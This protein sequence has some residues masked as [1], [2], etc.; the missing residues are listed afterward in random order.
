[1]ISKNGALFSENIYY[2]KK[3]DNSTGLFN[4]NIS[5]TTFSYPVGEI[6]HYPG[7]RMHNI[8][9]WWGYKQLN[10][11]Y[12]Y[13]N[14][15]RMTS[16]VEGSSANSFSEQLSY[17]KHGNI[18]SLT[19]K[20]ILENAWASDG[21]TPQ[22]RMGIID[23]LTF[24]PYQGNQILNVSDA[25]VEDQLF[26]GSQDFK[27]N[28]DGNNDYAYDANGNMVRDL[29][30]N[31]STIRYNFL[32]LPDTVQM[33]NG[34]YTAYN[35]DATGGIIRIQHRTCTGSNVSIPLGGTVVTNP[36][37]Y[38]LT[39][40]ANTEFYDNFV[41]ESERVRRFFID[42]G[43]VMNMAQPTTPTATPDFQYHFYLK[44]HLGNIRVVF[45]K[46]KGTGNPD[47][48][49]VVDQVNNYYPFG[50]EFGESAQ[51]QTSKTYQNHL[52][53]GK[54]FDNKFQ[55]NT[56]N[57]GARELNVDI[58]IWRT[59]D[60]LAEK[61]PGVSPYVY[62]L[63]NPINSIDPDGREAIALGVLVVKGL[64][65]AGIDIS[66]QMTANRTLFNQSFGQAFRNIDWTSAGGSFVAGA[67]GIPGVTTISKTAKVATIAT[68]V[69][70]DAAVDVSI[71]EGN[72]NI[73]NGEKSLRT[74]SIDA[75]GSLIGGKSS[76][77]IVKGAKNSISND[78]RSGTF[79]TLNNAEK[80]TLRQTKSV[81]NSQGF[82]AGTKTVVGLGTEI[83]KQRAKSIVGSGKPSSTTAPLMQNYTQPSDNTRIARPIYPLTLSK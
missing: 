39:S 60:P 33:R 70:V 58:P 30:K 21:F 54:E 41:Y 5:Q 44:D 27:D 48:L 82:E 63:N 64:I 74:A 57:F 81:V 31:I 28:Q 53:S 17:D 3:S 29:N 14:L 9:D 62:C 2:D 24:G 6:I 73:F 34:H 37:G 11:N 79:S 72:Q 47:S 20:G 49:L 7:W 71:A 8:G 69:A 59:V 26:M 61:Y 50:M 22:H 43:I 56:Y 78:I 46:A 10:F 75:V 19:R 1:M 38:S 35:R 40:T 77:D 32:N 18:Q 45:H 55:M 4:G 23:Q 83:G 15:N 80:N 13:D 42:D 16:A 68:A 65:G 12:T 51:D 67:V 76:D 52:F 66:I 25:S 36:S